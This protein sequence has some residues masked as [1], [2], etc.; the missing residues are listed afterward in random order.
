MSENKEILDLLPK[1]PENYFWRI[2]K[3]GSEG[4]I[5]DDRNQ[6]HFSTNCV[7]LSL[8]KNKHF[9][10]FNFSVAVETKGLIYVGKD[11][12]RLAREAEIM[13]STFQKKL[14]AS[15]EVK[16]IDLTGSYEGDY[17]RAKKGNRRFKASSETVPEK[18]INSS[19]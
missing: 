13:H 10:K 17:L 1:L 6:V 9:M 5:V 7:I 2:A 19:I 8:R 15:S 4:I 14:E 18:V 3:S 11:L 16:E 12:S